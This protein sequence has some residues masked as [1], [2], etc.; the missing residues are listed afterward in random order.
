MS[1]HDHSKLPTTA[2]K[3]ALAGSYGTPSSTNEYVTDDDPRLSGETGAVASVAAVA[4]FGSGRDG[5]GTFDGSSAVTGYSLSGST[6]TRNVL[7]DAHH[8]TITVSD[9]VTINMAGFRLKA[10]AATLGNSVRIH[11]D[12]Y[13]TTTTVVTAA[14]GADP[15]LAATTT[16]GA[17]FFGGAAGGVGRTS[18][19][20]G[21][22]GTGISTQASYG[23]RG[24]SGGRGKWTTT[25]NGGS[26]GTK[27]KDANAALHFYGDDWEI[28]L[29]FPY[30]RDSSGTI[31]QCAGGTGGGGGGVSVSGSATGI[32]AGGGGGVL[33]FAIKTLSC[34]TSCVFSAD[35]GFSTGSPTGTNAGVGGPGGGGGGLMVGFIAELNGSNLPSFTANGG[36]GGDGYANGASAWGE[37]GYG[38]LGGKITIFIGTNNVGGTPTVTANG[39]TKGANV[40]TSGSPPTWANTDGAAGTAYY[41][42]GLE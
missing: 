41:R 38:G 1:Y 18:N 34:G 16:T 5:S 24:G 31:A 9:N 36:N 28:L 40:D 27:S 17:T 2:Q 30:C 42:E 33:G 15:H 14:Q 12:G 20:T 23:G 39:G 4:L 6:Y 19:G 3:A 22:A 11:N 37:G 32:G 10:F 21:G 35:G 7:Y 29:G 25:Y 8:T 26:A 13:G